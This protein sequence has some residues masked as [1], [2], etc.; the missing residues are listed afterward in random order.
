MPD[1]EAWGVSIEDD[2]F[3]CDHCRGD[4]ELNDNNCCP[5]CDAQYEEPDIDRSKTLED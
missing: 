3:G 4:G 1:I 2:D 5:K